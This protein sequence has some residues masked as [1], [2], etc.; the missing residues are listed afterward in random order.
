MQLLVEERGYQRSALTGLWLVKTCLQPTNNVIRD[1]CSKLVPE[2][3]GFCFS[4]HGTTFGPVTAHSIELTSCHYRCKNCKRVT[5]GCTVNICGYCQADFS[6]LT[7]LPVVINVD[8]YG[9]NL[10]QP[11][12]QPIRGKL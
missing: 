1:T 12:I 10:V 9:W 6:Q 2:R 5:P 3:S 8:A 7:L 4:C 11:N